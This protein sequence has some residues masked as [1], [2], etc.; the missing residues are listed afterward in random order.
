VPELSERALERAL[1]L[2]TVPRDEVAFR[3]GYLDLAA[4][5]R[6]STGLAQRLM[7][8]RTVPIVYDRWWRP[9]LGRV[10]KGISGPSMA[11]ERHLSQRLL[12][13]RPG[14]TVLDLACGTGSFSRHFGTVV[15]EAGFVLG[16]DLSETMLARAARETTADWVVYVRADATDLPLRDA[17]VDAVCCFAAFHLFPEPWQA[18]DEMVRVLRPGGR[19]ALLTSLRPRSP[20]AR[21]GS[22]VGAVTGMRIFD[23][24]EVTGALSDRGLDVVEHRATG[25]IQIVAAK[26]R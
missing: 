7:T 19:L 14:R 11:D 26:Q 25:G 9:F 5:T 10:A 4:E 1:D 15:G 17:C 20:L 8:T 3:D 18:L 24:D 16:A 12:D 2:L 13:L 6:S 21:L 23:R 22:V